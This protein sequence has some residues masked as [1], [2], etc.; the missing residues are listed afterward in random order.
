MSNNVTRKGLAFGALVALTSTA[1][2]GAPAFATQLTF[3]PAAGTSYTTLAG[4]QFTLATT[5]A[6][7]FAPNSY[8]QLKYLV[9]TD[10]NSTVKFATSN[11]NNAALTT[12][13]GA[14]TAQAVS[15]TSSA[16][17]G[18]STGALDVS[19]IALNAQTT[20]AT[21]A[22]EVTA[23]V[24]AN[25]DG[26]LT[27][28]EWNAVRTVNF[29]KAGDIVPTVT[30]TAPSTGDTSVSATVAWGD[31]NIEQIS[32][33]KVAFTVAG[34]SVTDGTLASGTWSLSGSALASGA[35]VT[36]QAYI[37]STALGTAASATASA[38]TISDTVG[39]VS[40]VL[41]GDN[42]T[43][44]SATTMVT[45][46]AATVRT[47]GAFTAQVKATNRASTPAAAAG[48]AVVAT[49]ATSATLSSTAGSVV[50]ITING[51]T[52]TDATALAAAKF[53]LTTDASGLANVNVSTAGYTAG[54][55][56]TVTFAAQNLTSA[57]VATAADAA[58]TVS[59]DAAAAIRSTD[60]NTA[61][62]FAFSVKDQFG[63]LSTRTNERLV[64]SATQ[65]GGSIAT[66]YIAVSGGKATFSVT[67]ATDITADVTVAAALEVST[68]TN[69]SVSW[70]ANGTNVA[71]RTIKVKSAAYDFS[72]APAVA[73][74]AG[75]AVSSSNA[76]Q[77]ITQST[78]AE[79]TATPA[80]N[81]TY[82]QITL[83]GTA[84][85]ERLTAS[86]TG[87]YIS[88]DGA[89][90]AANT[91]TE[92]VQGT[93]VSVFVASNTVGTKTIT[94]TNGKVSKTV[95]VV[96]ASA[97]AA[98][99]TAA[100]F[101]VA[102]AAA[103]Q[104][105]RSIDATVTVTD[106]WGNPVAGFD[107]TASVAGVASV[108]GGFSANVTT[109]AN[110]KATVKLTAGVNDLGDAVVTFSDNDSATGGSNQLANVTAVAKT[111][112]FG[113]TDGYIDILNEK[114]ASVT[115]SMAKGKRVAFLLN[116][117]RKYN[118]VQT[119]DAEL[120]LQFN[121]RK[122]THN[123]KLIIGGVIV[124]DITVKITK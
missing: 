30:L 3:V 47:N 104:A 18:N 5:F 62:S 52:Y 31:L 91:D 98:E 93:S 17:A 38:R 64:V 103:A 59:D 65:T 84:A 85:G 120:N 82:A 40:N 4:Q 41:K 119:G 14:A 89:A 92:I 78:L 123:I 86:G 27:T 111:V 33:E 80:S 46:T 71:N 100:N 8:T 116:G 109:D 114:R 102:V 19:Y 21:S 58:F 48:V 79:L 20:S 13:V 35:A 96:F 73:Q 24:D 68:T 25:N 108:N 63:V 61:A 72:T 44:T 57:V 74:Y 94:V 101:A 45:N 37:G 124:D 12:A 115:W 2:A 23:F 122:G 87:V 6:P 39:L 1:I 67:P 26:A 9:K 112:V 22:V 118:F 117:V 110:G 42:A 83:V 99:G 16:V 43:G 51:T 113:Q 90:A 69:G 66:Q 11:A 77:V 7:G 107:A 29:K 56:V 34:G 76:A 88:I 121:L 28:G 95:D 75:A 54:R 49:V 15:T 53:N 50:S 81:A 36:A 105:G 97:S 70:A 55:T 106:K 32:N 10:A 60:K